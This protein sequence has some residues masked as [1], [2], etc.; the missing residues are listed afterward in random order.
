MAYFLDQTLAS[1]TANEQ[2]K[3]GSSGFNTGGSFGKATTATTFAKRANRYAADCT[4]CGLRVDAGKGILDKKNGAWVTS[5][6]SC[7]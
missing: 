6:S 5:H 4:N 3:K 1:L 2:G 7:P